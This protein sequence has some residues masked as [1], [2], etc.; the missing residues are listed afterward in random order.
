M[1][2]SDR[3]LL[4]HVG[5]HKT[6]TTWLQNN[7]LLKRHGYYR[8]LSMDETFAQVIAPH[9][10]A[11]DPAPVARLLAERR[12]APLPGTV[13]DVITLEAL[14]GLPYDG[15]RESDAYARRLAAIAPGARILITIREQIAI[16]TSVYMQHIRRAG[17]MSPRHFFDERPFTGYTK[18]SP[19]NFFYHRLVGL[20]QELF[21]A[22]NVLVLPMEAIARDQTAAIRRIAAFSGNAALAETGWERQRERGESYPQIAVPVLR[23]INYL[24]RD[25]LNPNP[26]IDLGPL[27]QGAYRGAGWLARQLPDGIR[28]RR[29]VTDHVRDRFAGRFAESNRRLAE[30]LSH[31]ID[32]SGYEGMARG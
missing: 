20:Y 14:S 30:Q 32:L 21:G 5:Y 29:P 9:G 6:A 3:P 26:V 10:L 8:I 28:R 7:V 4:L 13:A 25:A 15:G 1:S 22:D 19:E 11:F 18:F 31:D 2:A 16:M 24:R 12:A 17:T 27:G 23:R